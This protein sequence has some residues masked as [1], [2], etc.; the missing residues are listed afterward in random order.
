MIG[1]IQSARAS[2]TASGTGQG[3]VCRNDQR[4]A[5]TR[6]Q[7]LALATLADTGRAPRTL[8]TPIARATPSGTD[9]AGETD[10]HKTNGRVA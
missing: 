1:R 4:G 7:K 3:S 2:H 5:L 10:G 6:R 8:E 9:A